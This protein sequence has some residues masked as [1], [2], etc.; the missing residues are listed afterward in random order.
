MKKAL[1]VLVIIA[2]VVAGAVAAYVLL[3]AKPEAT[4]AAATGPVT[5]EAK[6][7][8]VSVVVEGAAVVEASQQVTLRASGSAVL[9]SLK[10]SGQLVE[11][12]G[13]V[14]TLDDSSLR[15]SQSQ[16]A[17]ALTQAELDRDKSSLALE[18]S[19]KDALDTKALVESKAASPDKLVLAEEAVKNAEIALESARVKVEMARLALDRAKLEL[20][21]ATVRAPFSG[22]VLKTYTEAGDLLG[23]NAP[24][25]LFGDVSMLRLSA[26]VDEFDI[27]KLAIGQQV[28]ISGDSVGEENIIAQVESIS[29]VAEIVNNISI[30]TVSAVVSNET[31]TL[32][33]GMS[34]DFSIRI[35]SDKGLV[36]P[37]KSVSTVRG[38]SYI[39][40]FENSEVVKKRVEIGAN[41]G[42]NLVVLSGIDEGALVVIPGAAPVASPVTP[43][44]ATSTAE[45]SVL[46]ITIPGSGGTK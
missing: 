15:N 45:K 28:T 27:A 23:T 34:T 2:V 3:S 38:R 36:V 42:I 18:R 10:R 32:R 24:I 16:A 33:P 26:E 20:Q 4:S 39:E 1:I 30:F 35:S 29:P 21:G 44:A 5:V 17:L 8:S 40:V 41:D 7:G 31:G 46:P 9:T 12:G 14:A 37:S 25:A 11:K 19:R 43:A 22:T 6:K 13:V